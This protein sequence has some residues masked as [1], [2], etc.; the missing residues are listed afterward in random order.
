[1]TLR[2]CLAATVLA[3][4]LAGCETPTSARYAV[5]AETNMALRAAGASGVAVGA[6][7]PPAQ[8]NALCR[9]MGDLKVADGITHTE[10]IR[11][12]L[13]SELQMAGA[14]GAST[15]APSG[16]ASPRVTLSGEVTQL[17]FSSMDAVTSGQW[18]IDLTLRSS[19]GRSLKAQARYAFDSGFLGT[20]GCR[21][22]AEAFP[23]AV[24]DLIYNT[25]QHSQFASLLR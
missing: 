14:T 8:F 6:F 19:N 21:Q 16:T 25:V 4:T 9:L 12:A 7:R 20:E 5:S 17:A 13:L 3:T 23:R 18:S 11:R 1:L 10:Y 24:Q 2:Q 22:T 15:G